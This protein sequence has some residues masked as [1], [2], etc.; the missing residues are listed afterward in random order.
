M[1]EPMK[2]QQ[3]GYALTITDQLITVINTEIKKSG[4]NV[5]EGLILSFRDPDYSAEKG[6]YH[7]VEISINYQGKIL[8]ITDFAYV[9]QGYY[10]ELEKEIDFD[11]FLGLMQHMGREYP[12]EQGY[13]LFGIWQQNFCAYYEQGVYQVTVTPS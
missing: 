3:E 13:E 9:G 11:L 6:G 2:I 8:Y 4:L 1:G 12:I 5:S 10:A 7:P